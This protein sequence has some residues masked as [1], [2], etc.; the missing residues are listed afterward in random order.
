M[1]ILKGYIEE[2]ETMADAIARVAVLAGQNEFNGYE[3]CC[4]ECRLP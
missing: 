3:I 2:G 1:K 4:R